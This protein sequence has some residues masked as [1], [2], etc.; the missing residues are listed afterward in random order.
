MRCGGKSGLV[1]PAAAL[2][3]L[4]FIGVA[5]MLLGLAIPARAG[6]VIDAV[7]PAPSIN[8]LPK[9]YFYESPRSQ[10]QIKRPVDASGNTSLMMLKAKGSAPLHYW[11][12]LNLSNPGLASQNLVLDIPHQKF[13][14]SGVWHPR[15]EGSLVVSIQ[16][17]DGPPVERLHMPASDALEITVPPGMP[18][19]LAIELV[20]GYRPETMALWHRSSFVARSNALK[21]FHGAAIGIAGLLCLAIACLFILRPL[22]V[23]AAAMLFA[24]PALAFLVDEFGY[25][26][27][28]SAMLSDVPLAA[29]KL[30]VTIEALMLAG[31]L[32]L[33]MSFTALRR[34]L[35]LAGL[36]LAALPVAAAGLAVY[37]WFA[38][39]FAI[40]TVRTAFV[41][42]VIGGF[43]V[44]GVLSG[45]GATRV[46]ATMLAWVAVAIWT[47]AAMLSCL[48]TVVSEILGAGISAGLVLVIM[49]VTIV[50]ARFGFADLAGN[51]HGRAEMSRRILALSSAEQSV[52]EW[53]PDLARLHVGPE[54]E[55]ALG[56]KAGSLC[57]DGLEWL[58]QIHPDDRAGYE[59]AIAAA[60][61]R[62]RGTF[63]HEFRLRRA[64][65]TYRWYQLRAR[66]FDSDEKGSRRLIGTLGDVTASRRSEDRILSDA[67]RDRVTGLPNRALFIDR[68]ERAMH[69]AVSEAQPNLYVLTIDLDR[70]KSVNDGLG[71]EVGDSLLNIIA[72]R[73]ARRIGPDDTLARLPGDQFAIIFN[74]D[75]PPRDV[76]DFA[77]AVRS[78]ISVP[79]N[80]RPREI[81]ITATL[82][83]AGFDGMVAN[84]DDFLRHAEI[85][86]FEAK[87]HGKDMIE[88]FSPDMLQER[89]HLISLEQ[90]LHRAMQRGEIEVVYQPIM[91]LTDGELAGFEA[92]VR[93]RH[94]HHGLL[95]P[96]S[97]MGLAEETGIVRELGR[98]VLDEAVRQL[99]VWKRAFRP[100]DP[101]FVSVNVSFAQL[102][103]YE[104]VDEVRTLLARE[105][106]PASALKLE[107]T[108]SLMMENPELTARVLQRM[109]E[110]GV[111][112]ACDDFGTG[113]SSL[114]NLH[115]LP[116]D[117]LKIDRALVDASDADERAGVV[118]NAIVTM[119]H[120]LGLSIVA[121]GV[122]TDAQ[123]RRLMALGCD[124]AQGF[125]VG[126]PVTAR[127]IA[128][129]FGGVSY[130]VGR[131]EGGFAGFWRR[132]MG[133]RAGDDRHPAY[134]D[135]VA[136]PET[137]VR[138]EATSVADE[139][140]LEPW[141][142][143]A[144]DASLPDLEARA[145]DEADAATIAEAAPIDVTGLIG[146]HANEPPPEE[147]ELPPLKIE[148]R[149]SDTDMPA[150]TI[151]GPEAEQ[152]TEAILE[153][154]EAEQETEA[155]LEAEAVL[156]AGSALEA[157]TDR[158]DAE[159]V[160]EVQDDAAA[161]ASE[162]GAMTS[163]PPRPAKRAAAAGKLGQRLRR[164]TRGTSKIA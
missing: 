47:L 87:R 134:P 125:L 140:D 64:D 161:P 86:L 151:P 143:P 144:D 142:P 63:A 76:V 44:L 34:R 36:V 88:F 100:S 121:E 157:E 98:F 126:R 82:G 83:V 57:G 130:T 24:W 81:F 13:A 30:Q 85:A 158:D 43:A 11:A 67:V 146:T 115:R 106:I 150:E 132:L 116:F 91:R 40:A 96:G 35:P 14:D 131:G 128:E 156:E 117:T 53:L 137:T 160:Q 75:K 59:S 74:G 135:N 8:I 84:P 152:E 145:R 21:F 124:L 19:T 52:W 109:S 101:L 104:L 55:R 102:L 7:F 51:G 71:H 78:D 39:Q 129:A 148:D 25:L 15:A 139:E 110:L 16:Q 1:L 111:T 79:V 138:I 77:D 33:F 119:A 90:D 127:Q 72:R 95:E 41:V 17:A 31:L 164:R 56:H 23:F 42:A 18:L 28:V 99:G 123:L 163:Q 32:S 62:G 2:R 65:G 162:D 120:G 70:F 20:G 114:V 48:G 22:P 10:V 153:E 93:W 5:L 66:A 73:L 60:V 9:L 147:V 45:H 69:R 103:N 122:E 12:V 113:Y 26:S 54:L 89:S 149:T 37:G 6:E 92:L 68:L 94:P 27:G 107:I 118:L 112:L 141:V 97:F 38:P 4:R 108:E 49:V 3:A 58:E 61:N 50:A 136:V 80:L 155:L 159:A 154:A 29:L 105:D 133:G 46:R